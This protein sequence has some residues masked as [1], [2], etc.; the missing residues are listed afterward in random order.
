MPAEAVRR[1]AWAEIDLAAVRH[2]AR[3][4]AAIAA[5]AKL[6]AVVKADAY[7]HCAVPV[8][9]AALEGGAS[10]LAVAVVDEGAELRERGVT[11]PVL[12]LSEPSSDAMSDALDLGLI[13]TLYTRDGVA[14]A[15]EAARALGAGS[16]RP[17][18]T[19]EVK[20]DTGM[21]RV[22]AS[23]EGVAEIVRAV[24]EAEVLDYGGL[25]THFAVAD[26]VDDPFTSEQLDR[27]EAVRS[28]LAAAGLPAPRRVHAANSAGAIAWPTARYDLVRC[29]IALYGYSPSTAVAPS[30]AEEL[31]RIKMAALQPVL[32]L[33]AKVT[34]VR[35]YRQG[36]RL[37]Y[38]RLRP[39][40]ESSLVATVPLGYADGVPR[41]Y[42]S[43]DG[44]VLVNGRRCALAG[45]VT[46]DQIVVACGPGAAVEVGDM[47]VLIGA[48]GDEQITADEWAKR[49]GTISYEVITRIG[50]RV[51]RYFVDSVVQ[52]V[53]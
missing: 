41:Q 15:S 33:K 36:E 21:H 42:F 37:S 19:V 6:C 27:F 20:V 5:P 52:A 29:G 51:P 14:A 46:M 25:W 12:V 43:S 1:P 2:N 4:L 26:E 3:A 8:A 38:G 30:L 23:P 53:S 22:G 34:L 50:P 32:A 13:P 35:E 40:S 49:L 39:L 9:V 48:Q 47:A 44:A 45:T 31:G 28:D 10:E 24:I 16:D 17:P 7:G 18:F 11:A